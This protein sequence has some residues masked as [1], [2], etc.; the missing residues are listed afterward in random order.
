MIFDSYNGDSTLGIDWGNVLGQWGSTGIALGVGFLTQGPSQ[1]NCLRARLSSASEFRRCKPQV[2]AQFDQ[3]ES[4]MDFLSP[5]EVITGANQIAAIFSD[6]N[7]FHQSK[8]G[9]F[10]RELATAKTEARQRADA[11]IAAVR[12]SIPAPAAAT[13]ALPGQPSAV[14]AA[15]A[16]AG[17]VSNQTLLMVGGGLV[18]LLLLR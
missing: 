10:G 1:G 17:G 11:I 6:D 8:G 18:L 4:I 12:A 15:A 14:S 2:M 9:D 3:L 5:P 16:T 7:F 13:Q